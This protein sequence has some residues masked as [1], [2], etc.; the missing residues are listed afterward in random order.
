MMNVL[1]VDDDAAIRSAVSDI[2]RNH[3]FAVSSVEDTGSA[4]A[5]LKAASRNGARR[6]RR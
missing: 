1:V 6:C 3:G 2:A 4:R 5:A